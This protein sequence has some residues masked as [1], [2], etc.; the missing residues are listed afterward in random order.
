MFYLSFSMTGFLFSRFVAKILVLPS[1]CQN[2]FKC[3]FMLQQ[4]HTYKGSLCSGKKSGK[5][6]PN[7]I[8]HR[9]L[10]THMGLLGRAEL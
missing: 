4:K 10:V 9:K 7:K 2:L 3:I 8:L 1:P 6:G 5:K